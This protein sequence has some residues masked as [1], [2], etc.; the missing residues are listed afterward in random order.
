MN[1]WKGFAKIKTIF[2]DDVSEDTEQKNEPKKEI[3]KDIRKEIEFATE[4]I[5]FPQEVKKIKDDEFK[6]IY[7]FGVKEK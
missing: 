7:D 3:K 2:Y 5:K 1:C 6:Y 4:E